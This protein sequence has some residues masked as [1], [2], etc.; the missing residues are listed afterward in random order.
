MSDKIL[1]NRVFIEEIVKMMMKESRSITNA[2][3]GALLTEIDFTDPGGTNMNQMFSQAKKELDDGPENRKGLLN[4]L[5]LLTD[6]ALEI[7][8]KTALI[9][10]KAA[11]NL[12]K[13]FFYANNTVKQALNNLTPDGNFADA[14]ISEIKDYF[15]LFNDVCTTGFE[16]RSSSGIHKPLFIQEPTYYCI[17]RA[18]KQSLDFWQNRRPHF[19]SAI[20]RTKSSDEI[21]KI[22]EKEVKSFSDYL[23]RKSSIEGPGS[24]NSIDSDVVRL[25]S[26]AELNDANKLDQYCGFDL[27]FLSIKEVKQYHEKIKI[28]V[29]VSL[30]KEAK[31]SWSNY[32]SEKY[33]IWFLEKRLLKDEKLLRIWM[34][35][36]FAM[37][38]DPFGEHSL[39]W[40]SSML[41][42]KNPRAAGKTTDQTRVDRDGKKVASIDE[43]T[44]DPAMVTSMVNVVAIGM[45]DWEM[46]AVASR[47]VL[48][49][50]VLG[51]RL[52]AAAKA[53]FAGGPWGSVLMLVGV[54]AHT[55]AV[56]Y[57]PFGWFS[58][59]DDLS[60]YFD[61]S[62]EEL[63][64]L[65]R[66][67]TGL[68][69]KRNPMMLVAANEYMTEHSI[70]MKKNIVAAERL[71]SD[72]ISKTV[73]SPI[74]KKG[75]GD[76]IQERY[77][78]LQQCSQMLNTLSKTF[79]FKNEDLFLAQF[80]KGDGSTEADAVKI[81]TKT[82]NLSKKTLNNLTGCRD[83]LIKVLDISEK[84]GQQ[85]RGSFF[86]GVLDESSL[87]DAKLV[88]EKDEKQNADITEIP[89]PT[90]EPAKTIK[91]PAKTIKEPA[92]TINPSAISAIEAL[93]TSFGLDFT[94]GSPD[95]VSLAAIELKEKLVLA[96]QKH[97]S[98]TPKRDPKRYNKIFQG[99]WNN[100]GRKDF[101]TG[102]GI[103]DP[104]P[105]VKM[106]ISSPD[107]LNNFV[108]A[109]TVKEGQGVPTSKKRA[110]WAI[111]AP[112]NGILN[113]SF[114]YKDAAPVAEINIRSLK[115][116]KSKVETR[117]PFLQ[118]I[119]PELKDSDSR[120]IE[121]T[122]KNA[123]SEYT[124]HAARASEKSKLKK[125][126]P[127]KWQVARLH[128]L[129]LCVMVEKLYS[130][131]V[132]EILKKDIEDTK[133]LRE[134]VTGLESFDK[135]E[136]KTQWE[137][138]ITIIN[139]FQVNKVYNFELIMSKY[140]LFS[141]QINLPVALRGIKSY[142][143]KT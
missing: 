37:H 80:S 55:A 39:D 100:F 75:S 143:G 89:K 48:Q 12:N 31:K 51:S 117:I 22:Y 106:A 114:Y 103:F 59:I 28:R 105:G 38:N 111:T 98:S 52:A 136:L 62:I 133:R 17:D 15:R 40:W 116:S 107:F 35:Y 14:E 115:K 10:R 95:S 54:L 77:V 141:K 61:R 67:L 47:Q 41:D 66:N 19:V 127:F 6:F 81:L 57:K 137:S 87:P 43:P 139:K 99:Q 74:L 101:G 86:S 88:L 70:E 92:K 93:A 23:S 7:M 104:K 45:A 142:Q 13:S 20:K 113:T 122:Y 109:Y 64:K 73:Q 8:E 3:D 125:R 26:S 84:M 83:T 132:R 121:E 140:S 68:M 60:V 82:I 130:K 102:T 24:D 4:K 108:Y 97:E 135:K 44:D 16:F 49:L 56:W 30:A 94:A 131:Q 78:L 58:D 120:S 123:Y 33:R 18:L 90:K 124:Q 72:S 65:I 129:R 126:D 32:L 128:V 29:A 76:K 42:S 34:V 134:L 63:E 25:L 85:M 2:P 53:G 71:L 69:N 50:G 96:S 79:N 118:S 9:S 46:A 5:S 1:A 110:A 27:L 21:S 91:E 119:F 138:S 36:C 11:K 112:L